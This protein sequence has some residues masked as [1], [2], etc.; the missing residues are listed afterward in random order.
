MYGG[1]SGW[2]LGDQQFRKEL[3]ARMDERGGEWHYG[4]E[5]EKSAEERAEGLI[6]AALKRKGWTE[7]NL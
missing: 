1:Q 6:R 7:K 5:W 3:L 2:F 4:E